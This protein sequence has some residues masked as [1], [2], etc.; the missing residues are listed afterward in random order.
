MHDSEILT[1]SNFQMDFWGL[2]M[3]HG[4]AGM[5]PGNE[6]GIQLLAGLALSSQT[7]ESSMRTPWPARPVGKM[8]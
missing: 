3:P 5:Y 4:Y 7:V 6:R 8:I 1:F 2:G